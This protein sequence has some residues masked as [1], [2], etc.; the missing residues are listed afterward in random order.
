LNGTMLLMAAKSMRK[1]VQGDFGIL[2]ILEG[3]LKYVS[4]GIPET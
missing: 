4:C 3:A 1:D 2:W